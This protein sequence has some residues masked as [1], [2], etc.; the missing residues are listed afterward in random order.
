MRIRSVKRRLLSLKVSTVWSIVY[1]R[2]HQP[3]TPLKHIKI[4]DEESQFNEDIAP[5]SKQRSPLIYLLKM[6]LLSLF[7]LLLLIFIL[8]YIIY[9][10]PNTIIR[11][12]QWRN[13]TVLF[14]H[15]LPSN[16]RVVALTIDDA[17][18]SS[19]G[20]ILDLLKA[21]NASATFFIIGS[22][23]T[24]LYRALIHRIHDEG[25]ELGN[26][27][28]KDEPSLSL[29]LSELSRQI[30]DVEALLPKNKNGK[31][32]FRPGS[33]VFNQKMVDTVKGLGY[34][35]VLGSIYPHDPQIHNPIINAKHVLS[36]VRPG[37]I[38]IMH[39]RRP[40]SLEQLRLV[41]EGLKRGGWQIKI[42][43]GLLDASSSSRLEL[44][45]NQPE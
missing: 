30:S 40:Y 10:P 45:G 25:H 9:K 37:G 3:N 29:P 5:F 16:R 4:D 35:T 7:I 17:P 22:Q 1:H 21:H 23:V 27:A 6:I 8:G 15:P 38:I 33:G 32:Y 36:M 11:F 24:P 20:Q 43:G 42:V 13:P 2:L 19:T 14:H 41:L 12:I 31:K 28:W 18:S 26:H 39:D 44:E 34:Q